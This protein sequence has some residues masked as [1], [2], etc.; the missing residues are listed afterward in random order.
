[1]HPPLTFDLVSPERLLFSK[2]VTMVTIPGGEGDY[3]VLVDHAPMITTVKP[4]VIEIFPH[5]TDAVSERLFVS[6]G[7]A[8]VTPTLCTVLADEAIPVSALNRG[9]LEEQ[10][11]VLAEKIAAAASADRA[12]LLAQQV[13][14]DA[15]L[16][17]AA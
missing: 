8:E 1:M 9:A 12:A 13:I 11:K 15:K 5:E 16:L 14:L 6:G 7:F 3:G 2:H 17:A 10:S 4:G